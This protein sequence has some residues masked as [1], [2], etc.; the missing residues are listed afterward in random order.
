[1]I[2]ALYKGDMF[3]EIQNAIYESDTLTFTTTKEYDI[4]KIM[5]WEGL[6][7]LIPTTEHERIDK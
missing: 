6:T 2:V 4:V 7:N 1:M 5:V 3:V